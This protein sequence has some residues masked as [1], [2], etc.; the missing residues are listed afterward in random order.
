MYSPEDAVLSGISDRSVVVVTVG[1][2]LRGTLTDAVVAPLRAALVQAIG[3]AVDDDRLNPAGGVIAFHG[4]HDASWIGY[5]DAR[6]RA[7]FGGYAAADLSDLDVWAT[8]AMSAGWWWPG[9]GVCVMAER[10]LAVHT[11]PLAGSH[12][13]E[14]RL[15]RADG[16]A[17]AFADGFGANVLHGTPVP[18]WVLSGLTSDLIRAEPNIEV[19]RSAIERLGWDAYLR[20][21]GMPL[22]ASCPDPGNPGARLE[23]YDDLPGNGWETPGRVLVVTNGT[24]EPDGHR[25]R[26]G[27][28]VPVSLDEPLDAA[29]WTYGLTG[30]QYVTLARRT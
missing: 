8:L 15:H 26:Y 2:S 18:E 29:A 10:P 21:G 25:R 16:P 11:E 3:G 12:H 20:D 6:R 22:V 9:E 13:G 28:N 19:R 4:Q 7:G 5:Y 24:P 14:Q 17:I 23:L 1:Q 30:E 27:I